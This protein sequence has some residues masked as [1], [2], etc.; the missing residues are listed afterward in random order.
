[1]QNGDDDQQVGAPVVDITHPEAERNL[2]GQDQDGIIG[3][4]Y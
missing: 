3:M 4:I 2:A 1:V